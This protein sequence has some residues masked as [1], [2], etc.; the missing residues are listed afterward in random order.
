MRYNSVIYNDIVNGEGQRISLFVQGCS[1]HCKDCFNKELGWDFNG[2]QEF[3]KDKLN[4][5][6]LV[7]KLYKEGYSGLSLLGGEPFQN[8]EISNLMVGTFRQEFKNTKTIWIWSGYTFEQLIKD[9]YKLDLLKKCDV[10][11]DGKF[12]KE[13]YDSQLKFRGSSN[14]RIINVQKSLNKNK[15]IL[16][17]E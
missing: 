9:E 13:L 4:E 3:T 7:F 14:Q 8:L 5:I 11:V 2:G 12:N 1:H 6:M 10:L 17:M 15:V 16:Y